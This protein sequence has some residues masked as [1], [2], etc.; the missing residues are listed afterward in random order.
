MINDDS[1]SGWN[2]EIVGQEMPLEHP[3]PSETHGLGQ[4]TIAGSARDLIPTCQ[5]FD[6]DARLVAL[7]ELVPPTFQTFLPAKRPPSMPAPTDGVKV[8]AVGPDEEAAAEAATAEAISTFCARSLPPA[9]QPAACMAVR[10]G[11]WALTPHGKLDSRAML[12]RVCCHLLSPPPPPLPTGLR[13]EM[14]RQHSLSNQGNSGSGGI[15]GNLTSGAGANDASTDRGASAGEGVCWVVHPQRAREWVWDAWCRALDPAFRNGASIHDRSDGGNI[16]FCTGG[17]EWSGASHIQTGHRTSGAED[18]AV[19]THAI[20]DADPSFVALGGA[21][22]SAA[23]VCDELLARVRAHLASCTRNIVAHRG[24]RD[25]NGRGG[26][27]RGSGAPGIAGDVSEGGGGNHGT[28][29]RENVREVEEEVALRGRLLAA[30][31]AA[32]LS[33]S[34]ELLMEAILQGARASGL[35]SG[36]MKPSRSSADDSKTASSM[37]RSAPVTVLAPCPNGLVSHVSIPEAS[38]LTATVAPSPPRRQQQQ[39]PLQ[40]SWYWADVDGVWTPP[41][42]A[43]W[44]RRGRDSISHNAA[45]SSAPTAP[46]GTVGQVPLSAPFHVPTTRLRITEAWRLHMGACVDAPS[47][48]AVFRWSCC[49]EPTFPALASPGD[50][51][52]T[53]NPAGQPLSPLKV[54]DIIERILF[55]SMHGPWVAAVR[56]GASTLDAHSTPIPDAHAATAIGSTVRSDSPEDTDIASIPVPTAAKHGCGRAPLLWRISL[57]AGAIASD[58]GPVLC[59]LPPAVSDRSQDG[60]MHCGSDDACAKSDSGGHASRLRERGVGVLVCLIDGSIALLNAR[61][62]TLCGRLHD[63]GPPGS[64]RS[65]PLWAGAVHGNCGDGN[66]DCDADSGRS[67]CICGGCCDDNGSRVS[68]D[69]NGSSKNDGEHVTHCGDDGGDRGSSAG[70]GSAECAAPMEPCPEDIVWMAG[71]GSDMLF[72]NIATMQACIVP[73]AHTTLASS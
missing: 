39:R 33:I 13:D 53:S 65:P 60:R 67:S 50:A 24:G 5:P 3:S 29:D 52:P 14:A 47:V 20:L 66:D 32:P 68:G 59:A 8:F 69:I 1:G 45:A 63:V 34:A 43:V 54:P 61:T 37:R 17:S 44:K 26:S 49:P 16:G 21:S 27:C 31:I 22:L 64:V 56:L 6:S 73:H 15:A 42:T 72:L 55:V 51:V 11:T 25:G 28:F 18:A 4:A 35:D 57:G 38:L 7:F 62:G 9:M 70:D 19:L 48:V 36:T 41:A 2:A 23:R 12:S 71:Y 58:C 46:S 10:A 40:Q 30:T